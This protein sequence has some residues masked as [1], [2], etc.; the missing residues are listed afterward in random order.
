MGAVLI[1]DS[2]A[3]WTDGLP[4]HARHF[5]CVVRIQAKGSRMNR[6]NFLRI[7]AGTASSPI[8][9]P[10]VSYFLPPVGGWQQDVYR[11]ID[12]YRNNWIAE[13]VQREHEAMKYSMYHLG[14]LGIYENGRLISKPITQEWLNRAAER[15]YSNG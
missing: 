12:L 10:T 6:R 5:R 15:L 3:L 4:R 7:L 11:L 8:I 1:F 13:R 14:T 9:A 2:Q